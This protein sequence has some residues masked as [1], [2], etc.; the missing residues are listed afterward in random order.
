MCHVDAGDLAAALDS[1]RDALTALLVL[2]DPGRVR[3]GRWMVAWVLRL[4]GRHAE[5]LAIQ[6]EL[7]EELDAA[8]ETDPYVDEEL[9]TLETLEGRSPSG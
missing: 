2:G 4:Q 3:V 7:K 9:A 6:R 5:A 1:F 8:G